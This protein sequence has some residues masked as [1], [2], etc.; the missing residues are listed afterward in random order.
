MANE[1]IAYIIAGRSPRFETF[2]GEINGQEASP[3]E[4]INPSLNFGIVVSKNAQIR[5][6]IDFP[7]L[8]TI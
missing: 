5:R 2:I 3:F 1:P 4:D 8:P 7:R 6:K